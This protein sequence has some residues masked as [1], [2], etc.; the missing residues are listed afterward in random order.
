[1]SDL[2]RFGVAMDRTLL[3]EF[4]RRVAARGDENRSE[5]L[6]DLIRSDLTRAAW[7]Q[8]GAVAASLTLVYD[9]DAR[10]LLAR[11]CEVEGEEPGVVVGSLRVPLAPGR[12]LE[13][14]AVKGGGAALTAL[15]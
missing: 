14:L 3:S 13:I 7:D 15:A 9:N 5:A 1:M 4:D 12:S 10:D 8:G 11:L 2:V 6:R